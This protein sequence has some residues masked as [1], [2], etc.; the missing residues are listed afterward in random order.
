MRV[1][2]LSR[3][4]VELDLS[5]PTDKYEDK[6]LCFMGFYSKNREEY[7]MLD[8]ACQYSCVTTVSLYDT[9]GAEST[10]FIIN[11]TQLQTIAC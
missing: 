4:I 11:Q 10:A 2:T 1:V 3:A 7:V 8:F 5:P 9:L 6:D